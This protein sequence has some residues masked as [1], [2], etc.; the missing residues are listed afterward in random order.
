MKNI[1]DLIPCEYDIPIMGITDDS[2]NVGEG[3]LFVATK[4]YH[5]D[6]YDYIEDAI[7]NGCSFVICDR[8]IDFNI[9]HIVVDNIN[10]IYFNLCRKYYEIDLSSFHLIGITGTDGKTTTTTVIHRLLEDCAY[11]GTN[12]VEVG[13]DS[14]DTHNTTPCVDELYEDLSIIQKKNCHTVSMEVSS[15]ALLHDRVHDFL[16]DIVGFTNITGDH[17]NIHHSFDDYV[18]CK[19]QL[20]DHLKEDG[21]VVYNGDDEHISIDHPHSI[22]FGFGP[23]NQYVISHVDYQKR[24]TIITLTTDEKKWEIVSP[25]IGQYNVYNI[26]M[27]FLICRLYGVEESLLLQRIQGLKPI[28][29]RCEFLD[30]GQD[31]DIVLDYAHTVNGISSIL[32][33]FSSY[34]N[35]IVVTGCAG[36]RETAKRKVIGSLILEK[37][38]ISIFTMDDP[39]YESVDS[40]IDQMVGDAKDYIR[41]V[42]REEAIAYALSIA[43]PGSVVLILGKGRD[44]YMAIEDKKVPY[45]DYDVIANYFQKE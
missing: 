22:A 21:W 7:Q 19:M 40:I 34:E 2:R 6:H 29:G 16:F 39:R 10:E 25:L 44:N 12:G 23:N 24:K 4:G 32:D 1:Q 41:I 36:G 33:T 11:I 8:E 38:D 37:S 3:F 20:L 45:N 30:F 35:I 14:F 31:Y 9:P 13:N 15:E 26:V 17:L 43:S 18:S 28:K 5:V 27:A 42:D